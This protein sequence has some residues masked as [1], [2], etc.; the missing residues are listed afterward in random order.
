MDTMARVLGGTLRGD[1]GCV[2][3]DLATDSRTLA[4][5]DGVLFVALQGPNHDGHVYLPGLY[6]QGVRAFLV[7]EPPDEA[8]FPL[9]SFCVVEDTLEGLQTLAAHRRSVYGGTVAAITGSNGKTMVK[10]WIYQCLRHRFRVHRSP[11]SYNSQVGVPLSVWMTGEDDE[12]AL[13]EAGISRPGEMERLAAIIRP[14]WGL[15][16]NLGTAHEQN[17]RNPLEK[18]NEKLRLFRDC[19]RLIY[20]ADQRVEGRPLEEL[21]S[22]IEANKIGWSMKSD[23]A[24]SYRLQEVR[25]M[26]REGRMVLPDGSVHDLRLPFTDDASV[27]NALHALTFALEAGLDP[28]E[29]RERIENLEP[30]NMRLEIVRGIRNSLLINDAYNADAA[31]LEAGLDLLGTHA[32]GRHRVLILS[33]LLQSGDENRVYARVA[34]LVRTKKV[35]RFVGVGPA[36][37]RHRDLFRGNSRFFARTATFL[38]QFDREGLRDSVVLVKGSRDFQ[39]ETII[40]EFQMQSHQSVLEVDLGAMARNL[41]LYR[42]KLRNEVKVMVMVKALSYGSGSTEV[43]QM[44][45]FQKVDALAVAFVDEGVALR[46]AGIRLPLVVLNPDPASFDA[47]LDFH[48]EPEVYSFRGLQA[49]HQVCAYRRLR[50]VPIHVKLDTGM[51]RLGF[52]E[53]D[54]DRLLPLLKHP[55]FRVDSAFSHLAASE[56]PAHD[57]F[58]RDQIAAFERMSG[59]IRS[60]LGVPFLRHVLNSSGIERFPEAQF[61]MVRLGIGLHGVGDLK[62]LEPVSAFRTRVSQVRAL[63]S[64][65]TVGYGRRGML[66]RDSLVAT[67]PVG[68]AD[69]LDRRLGLGRGRVWIRGREFPLLGNVCMDMCMVDVTGSGVEEGDEVEIFGPHVSV[70]DLARAASTIPYEILTSI[71]ERVKRVYLQD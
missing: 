49:L 44:L 32:E 3:S 17:F 66:E 52:Q 28:E 70:R 56:D 54:V 21:L 53:Q 12:L 30:V 5:G 62:G 41:N 25:G 43:A 60:E 22:G 11:K 7:S 69:G 36:L 42:Q 27:E 38:E 8:A 18:L 13:F 10:E 47:M 29:A 64:G 71:P 51:H 65:E 48:L 31:G 55:E 19:E 2:I 24:Y 45:Q 68:Y 26:E 34:E 1:P 46:R 57:E 67:L 63:P 58:T 50:D 15:L 39:F 14:R 20:C 61:D 40:R 35:D 23:A 59:R 16:T 4:S 37:G 33:D 6:A 9:A